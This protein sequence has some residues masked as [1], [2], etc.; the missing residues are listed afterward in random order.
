[1]KLEKLE[2]IHKGNFLSYYIATYRNNDGG[3]KK[4]ELVSRNPN[5]SIE[6]FKGHNPAGVGLVCYSPNKDKIL[7]E[8][9][10]RL[11]C[12]EFVYNFPAGLID[13]NE[14]VEETAKRELKEETGVDL[15]NI[16]DVLPPSYASQ[17]T[18]DEMM[19]LIICTCDGEITNS[20]YVDEEIETK[21]YTKDEVKKL[22][23]EKAYMS[24]RTQMFLYMW[25]NS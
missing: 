13:P 3:I 17:G 18:S 8:K 15:I 24:V 16:I 5:L 20:C 14:G 22:F 25:M 19:T 2:L 6:T 10:F 21:W 12:N 11:A 4:Y 23:E 7:L 9:E 1:M